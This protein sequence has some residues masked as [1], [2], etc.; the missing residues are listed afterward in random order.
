MEWEGVYKL[1]TGTVKLCASVYVSVCVCVYVR[2]SVFVYLCGVY[3]YLCVCTVPVKSL[4]TWET[5]SKLLTGTVQER[6]I[7]GMYGLAC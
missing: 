7:T 4:D 6:R 3:V 1:L 2:A 5:V